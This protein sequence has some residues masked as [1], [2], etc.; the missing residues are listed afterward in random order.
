M[1]FY[2]WMG[3]KITDEYS[4][5]HLTFDQFYHEQLNVTC[6]VVF[7]NSR[8]LLRNVQNMK[9]DTSLLHAVFVKRRFC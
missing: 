8:K 7:R 3:S 4:K 1:C 5:C 9:F 6:R 2:S